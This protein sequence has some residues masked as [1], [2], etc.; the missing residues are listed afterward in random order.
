MCESRA[1]RSGKVYRQLFDAQVQLSRSLLAGRT[2]TRTDCLSAEDSNTHC[3]TTSR[4]Q[5]LDTDD[6]ADAVSRLPDTLVVHDPSSDIIKQLIE[7]RG[8]KHKEALKQ[9]EV[10]LTAIS[11]VCEIQVRTVSLELQSSLQEVDLRLNTLK[12]QIDKLEHLE[13]ISLQEVCVL[14]QQVEEQVKLKKSRIMELNHKLTESEAQRADEIKG[15]LKTYRH[16]LEKISF[17]PLPVVCRLIHSEATMLNQSLLANRRSVARL[18]LLLQEENLQQ[19]S[20]LRLHW[21]DC[22][23]CWRRNRVKEVID[24]F[25]AFCS[26]EEDQQLDLVW[27]VQMKRTQRVLTEQRSDIIHNICLLVPPSCSTALVS[28][29]F[30]QLTAVNQQIESLHADFLHQLRQCYEQMWNDRLAE[31]QRC[32]EALSALQLSEEEVNDVV[33]SQLLTLIGRSQSQDEE[34]LTVLDLCYDCVARHTLSLSRCVFVVMRGAALLWETHSHRLKTREEE[35][36]QHLDDLRHSQQQHTQRKKV[37]LDDLLAGLRQESSEDALKTSLDKTV[38][39]LQDIQHSCAVGVSDQCQLLDRLPSVFLDDLLSYSSSISSFFH[40]DHAYTP[41]PEELQNLDPSSTEPA[42]PTEPELSNKPE[43]RTNNPP[44]TCQNDSTHPSQD[45]LTEADSAL[46]EICDINTDVMFTSS[47]GVAYGG[48]AF[49]CLA[50]DLPDNLQQE[51]HLSLF[52]VEL[53]TNTLSSV[54]TLFFDHLEQRFHDVLSLAV[55]MVT[56]RKEAVHSELEL[57]LQD[58]NPEHIETQIYQ[59]RLAELQVHSQLVDSHCEAVSHLLT[60][61]RVE[62]EELQSTISK[63]NQEFTAILFKMEDSALTA[64]SSQRLEALSSALQDCLDQHIKDTQHCETTFR[65]MVQTRLEGVRTRTT[66]VLNSF[67]LFSEGGDFAP[68]E[69]KVFQRRLKEETK[70]IGVTEESIFSELE[71]FESKSLQQ[72]KEASSRF[73][74]KLSLLKSEVKFT[75][76]TQ[77]VLSSTRVHIKAEAACSNQ[78]Q[79][80]ITSRLEELKRMMENRQ[81]HTQVSPDQV[82][83]FLSS[84][85]EGLVRRCQYLDFSLKPSHTRYE[86][87]LSQVDLNYHYTQVHTQSLSGDPESM[88]PV[89]SGPLSGLL[90]PSRT[91]EELLDDPVI[92]IIRSLNRVSVVHDET[93]EEDRG[94]PAADPSQIHRLHHRG[95][96]SVTTLRA[97]RSIRTDRRFQVFGPEPDAKVQSQFISIVTLLLWKANDVLLLVA[98]DFYRSERGAVSRLLLLPDSLDK[99]AESMQQKLLGY[100][101]QA[102]KFLSTSREELVNQLSM[103]DELLRL[104]PAVMIGNHE[105]Q[106]GAELTEDMGRVRLK[107]EEMLATSEKEKRLNVGRLRVSLTDGELEAVNAD[108]EL[109]QQQLHTAICSTHLEVQECVRVRGE[110][111]VTSLGSLTEKLMHQLDDLLTPAETNGSHFE[112][113]SVTME[114]GGKTGQRPCTA[115]R[116]W[117]GISYPL[118]LT[119]CVTTATTPSITTTKCTLGHLAV[120]EQRDTAVTRFEQLIRSELLLSDDDKRRQVREL[121]SWNKHWRQQIHTL[122]H[123]THTH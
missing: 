92:G 1:V 6:D 115:G 27:T 24:C 118:S 26:S 90:R 47:K 48:P 21:E 108:E 73:E 16:L 112:D 77:K 56:V 11:Q 80:S 86:Q 116:T 15:V 60:S 59:P 30:N 74:E 46:L 97:G 13:H 39:Y 69:V 35:L 20:L 62:L 55:A 121:Q 9:L 85:N 66:E 10:E 61:C 91:S 22:L 67:R 41:S 17:L 57:E 114:T 122:K 65:Q 99:W 109:R 49:R 45:W 38:C 34:R 72:V 29:W 107:L 3:S 54:R 100:Q 71:A 53:L 68:R 63:K 58:F 33:N 37:R 36:Q 43:K 120:I 64:D 23:S 103:L 51:T 50:P 81:V 18:L 123:T 101:E 106:Q 40:L 7:K 25:R 87:T 88:K 19:E 78:Q 42:Q 98:E 28:D 95:S 5:R 96:E 102:R 93:A 83:S 89:R 8:K 75:E 44:I 117:S 82:C 84:L 111:F 52:P 70:E 14:W 105:Q 32:Q 76:K 94:R 12:D 113:N 2:D 104:L 110:E 79:L 4:G 31:V 119:S